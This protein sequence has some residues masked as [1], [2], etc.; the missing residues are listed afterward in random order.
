MA[1]PIGRI[2]IP[3]VY[4]PWI[5]KV[6]GKENIPKNKP[7][8]IAA[9]HSSYFDTLLIPGIMVR[10]ID[11]KMN[12]WVNSY[13]WGNF[14]TRAFLDMWGAIPVHVEKD[15]DAKEKNKEAFSLT[16]K[17]LKNNEPVMIFPEGGRN[18]GK[19]RK[20]Y[21]GIARLALSAKVPVLPVGIIGASRVMPKG[22]MLPRLARCEVK[23]G[24][25]MHFDKYYNKQSEKTYGQVTRSIMKEIGRLIGQ[26][27]NY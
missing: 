12:A 1:Y 13:Y 15:K 21:P 3:A 11:G 17:C 9:N 22:K 5:R 10:V 7:F 4:W 2:L 6:E 14:M 20:A 23:I 24:K 8:I 27:Y 18:D 19:L 16:I 26:E 25:L